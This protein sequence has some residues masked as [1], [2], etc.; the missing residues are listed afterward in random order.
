M[1][2]DICTSDTP[3]GE[4]LNEQQMTSIK[5]IVS[6]KRHQNFF[7]LQAM[8]RSGTLQHIELSVEI[9]DLEKI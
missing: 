9:K 6:K 4:V 8:R 5:P 3:F 2:K 1:K 7:E